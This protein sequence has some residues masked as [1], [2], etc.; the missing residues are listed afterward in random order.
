MLVNKCAFYNNYALKLK[1]KL[2]IGKLSNVLIDRFI[3]AIF[4]CVY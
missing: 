1:V 4:Y 3:P 2:I